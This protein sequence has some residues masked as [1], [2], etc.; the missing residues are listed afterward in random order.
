MIQPT[1]ILRNLWRNNV[2]TLLNI[3]GLAVGMTAAWVM[4]HYTDFEF[5]FDKQIPNSDRVFRV[6][7][8]FKNAQGEEFHNSGC[9]EPLWRAAQEVAGLRFAVPVHAAFCMAVTPEG[10]R[11]PFKDV[12]QIAHTTPRYFEIQP[13]KWLAGSP[14]AA[15]TQPDQVVL[16]RSRAEKYFPRHQPQEVL[17]KTL[18]Y[19]FSDDTVVATVVGV[20][21]DLDFPSSFFEKE[22]LTAAAPRE[23]RWGGVNSNQQTWVLLHDASSARS[24][25]EAI[26]AISGARS[27]DYAQRWNMSRW[28]ELQPLLQ[29]HTGDI[30]SHLPY[31][32]ANTLKTLSMIALFLLLLAC[33][34]YINMSTAQIPGRAREIGIRKTI[35]GRS[36]D[37]TG[38]FLA[39]TA[40]VVLLA[41]LLAG[42][43]TYTCFD[44]FQDE[45]PKEV[46]KYADWRKTALFLLGL[47]LVVVLLSGLYPAWLASRYQPVALLRAQG[48]GVLGGGRKLNVGLRR[49]LIVFQFFVAQVFI[50]GAFVVGCQLHFMRT[51]DLG[52]DKEAVI[53]FEQPRSAWRD[54]A[55]S[56]K[57]AVL[58]N[59]LRQHPEIER[60]VLGD[61]P[62]SNSYSSNEYTYTDSAGNKRE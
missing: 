43:L 11:S 15:L 56:G 3:V 20:V 60:V 40:A 54:P 22:L 45:L 41:A 35:G 37:I 10:S 48:S 32:N 36:W 24:V 23:D 29:V 6:I 57:M 17:G 62:L 33:I 27:A 39:E 26:T 14:A 28:H 4:W 51:A 31:A 25:A 8:K 12:R 13:S 2:F 52:F 7:S 9:P 55:Q 21:E 61:N 19:E 30:G 34:N 44:Y 49:G 1:I 18:R 5:G 42:L 58:A 59:S 50:I 38:A 47:F 53:T 46:L 16:A